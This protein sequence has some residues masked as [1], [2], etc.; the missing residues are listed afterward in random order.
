MF[1][2]EDVKCVCTQCAHYGL[3]QMV[4]S[5]RAYAYAGDMP[6]LQCSRLNPNVDQFVPE[7]KES[8]INFNSWSVTSNANL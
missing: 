1:V 8:S 6:C 5:G 7:D 3:Y 4:T 2:A